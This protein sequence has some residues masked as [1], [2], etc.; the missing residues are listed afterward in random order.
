MPVQYPREAFMRASA[1]KSTCARHYLKITA[2]GVAQLLITY[3][4]KGDLDAS[5]DD[6]A[7]VHA[8]A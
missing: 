6:K 8:Q 4:R 5:M 2:C 1:A 7:V 3:T